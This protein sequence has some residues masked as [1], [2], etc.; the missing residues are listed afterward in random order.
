VSDWAR[1]GAAERAARPGGHAGVALAAAL[2]LAAPAP[3]RA[4]PARAAA[5]V[6]R[7]AAGPA[8]RIAP[9]DTTRS[10]AEGHVIRRIDV[11]TRNVFEPVPG[12]RLGGLERL[13]NRLH[14]RTR[15]GTVRRQLLFEPGSRWSD[16]RARETARNMRASNFLDPVRIEAR[17][18]RDSALALVETRDLW[19][20]TPRF[21]I[22]S[23]DGRHVGSIGITDRNVL[24]YGKS[25]SLSYRDDE[26]GKTWHGAYD[27][28]NLGGGRH[29]L[30]VASA[31]G[32]EGRSAEF[33]IGL[34][35]YAEQVVRAYSASWN[36][37]TFVAHLLTSSDTSKQ[38]SVDERSERVELW[39]GGRRPDGQTIRRLIGTFDVWDRGLGPSRVSPGAP[40]GFRG[41]EENIRIRRLGGEAVL[42]GPHFIERADINRFTRTEDFDCSTELALKLGFAPQ[43]FGSTKD[44]GFV[45][46]RLNA[47]AVTPAGFGWAR[48]SGSSRLRREWIERILQLDARWYSRLRPRHLL[49]LGASGIA[50]LNTPRDFQARAGGLNGLRAF[51]I[52]ALAGRQLW[53]LNAEERWRFSPAGWTFINLGSAVFFD[54]ARAWGTG[55]AGTGWFRNAGVGLRLGIPSW[56]LSEVMRVDVA[57]PI[58]PL[59]EG[60]RPV[61][62]LGSNQAF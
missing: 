27:D 8:H 15:P 42:R 25:L 55:A 28:P 1:R 39:F 9:A 33:G 32:T 50:G 34:P 54:A 3:A 40:P 58:E 48:A 7:A 37:T 2:L 59:R 47:G 14:V 36:R 62:T 57:W 41:V 16:E 4:A 49:A 35:F 51:P 5:P 44:E 10:A 53:R 13:A 30:H 17:L 23:A 31:T 43:A 11:L 6:P 24:G 18:Q 12:S 22:A 52:D 45:G 20:M 29:R 38:A 60:G 21:N 56:G 26:N 61:L 19:T 46:M